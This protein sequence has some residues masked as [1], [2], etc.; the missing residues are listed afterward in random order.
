VGR[1]S[2]DVE[3]FHLLLHAGLSR[4]FPKINIVRSCKC[5]FDQNLILRSGTC[6]G[7]MIFKCDFQGAIAIDGLEVSTGMLADCSFRT[8]PDR[9]PNIL[10]VEDIRESGGLIRSVAAH[11]GLEI[12]LKRMTQ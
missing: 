10:L 5:Q 6:S 9:H 12:D 2:F 3:L 8:P 7:V 4:R 1:Y 11:F